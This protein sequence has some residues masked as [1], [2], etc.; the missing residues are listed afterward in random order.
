MSGLGS[1]CLSFKIKCAA[2]LGRVNFQWQQVS[3]VGDHSEPNCSNPLDFALSR[4]VLVAVV[5]SPEVVS[6]CLRPRGLQHA[7]LFC[8]PL[9]P[10]VC[11]GS[12][13]LS[14]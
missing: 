2:A 5:F 6:N 12:C 4:V 7:R 9:S 3:K 14:Q 8:P 11:S 10:D 1:H 13:P